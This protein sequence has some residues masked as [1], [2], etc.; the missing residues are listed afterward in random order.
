MFPAIPDYPHNTSEVLISFENALKIIR[1]VDNITQGIKKI[2]YLVGWQGLGHDDLYPDMTA[3]ND[4][5]KRDC[6]PDGKTSLLWLIEEAKKYNTV[7]SFHGNLADAYEQSPSFPELAAA[8]NVPAGKTA[9]RG[10]KV[11]LSVGSG[12]AY[13]LIQE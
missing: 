3:V 8:G 12:E 4:H 10:G 6:D 11:T 13:A 7:V 1:S 9:I 5:L 2:V